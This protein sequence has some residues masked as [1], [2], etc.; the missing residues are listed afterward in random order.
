MKGSFSP[1]SPLMIGVPRV[2]APTAEPIVAMPTFAMTEVPIPARMIGAA[3]QRH[4]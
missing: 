1:T 4:P 2:S 3:T